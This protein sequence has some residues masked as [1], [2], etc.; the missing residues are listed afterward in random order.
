[1]DPRRRQQQQARP[2]AAARPA[3]RYVDA[4]SERTTRIV[5]NERQ[6][7]K[8]L[9]SYLTLDVPQRFSHNCKAPS[10][11][12]TLHIPTEDT[13]ADI[14]KLLSALVTVLHYSQLLNRLL[15]KKANFWK[16][17][18][19]SEV[20]TNMQFNSTA[21]RDWMLEDEQFPSKVVLK[22]ANHA[23]AL[24]EALFKQISAFFTAKPDRRFRELLQLF[25][26]ETEHV[27]RCKHISVGLMLKGIKLEARSVKML[28]HVVLDQVRRSARGDR[29][30]CL[31]MLDLSNNNM[32][33]EALHVVADILK[34]ND[35]YKLKHVNLT[36][37]TGREENLARD[38]SSGLTAIIQASL[39]D[40]VET[41]GGTR[42]QNT[43]RSMSTLLL[44]ENYLRVEHYT[45]LCSA[46]RYDE[47]LQELE[48]AGTMSSGMDENERAQCWQWIAFGLFYRRLSK[49]PCDRINSRKIDLSM[50]SFTTA[51][52]DAFERA[53]HTP[54]ELLECHGES[55]SISGKS[56]SESSLP[57]A[58]L[59]QCKIKEGAV[60]HSDPDL[61]SEPLST[62][63]ETTQL[64]CL[65]VDD[66]WSCV[67]LP[68]IGLGWVETTGAVLVEQVNE[69]ES[70][71]PLREFLPKAA[72]VMNS[73]S[74][75]NSV[76]LC[77]F[78]RTT[79]QQLVSLELQHN[80]CM[81][82][83]VPT[84]LSYCINLQCLSLEGWITS[85]RDSSAYEPDVLEL[86]QALGGDFGRQLLSLDLTGNR[87]DDAMIAIL[88]ASLSASHQVPALQHL[89]LCRSWMGERGLQSLSGALKVNRTL[90][91]L[92]LDIPAGSADSLPRSPL[93]MQLE[94]VRLDEAFDSE[95]LW[96]DPLSLEAKLAFLSVLTTFSG[97]SS[98][99]TS[100]DTWVVSS[101]FDFAR[102]GVRRR[103][104]WRQLLRA[105][106]DA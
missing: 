22:V 3:H 13:V 80:S 34:R 57:N 67:V 99:R 85:F 79:G 56:H 41:Y 47:T 62:V 12:L 73:I 102:R 50:S 5:M 46:L 82:N 75:P 37:I 66:H 74:W 101:V 26:I 6:S 8:S 30:F 36:N 39:G 94:A 25:P 35:V 105:E 51:D 55:S 77:S 83:V 27:R 87:I 9:R 2:R 48:L 78:I 63:K 54:A 65:W 97:D 33:A 89:R 84:I 88:A 90:S 18:L 23:G 91:C 7:V 60:I 44:N 103:I 24:N 45:A 11:S 86:F 28:Q 42:Q 29:W 49:S 53:L 96:C 61:T 69:Q 43:E 40:F 16:A 100:I 10:C 19:F 32:D 104:I 72:V 76:P 64:E 71:V 31:D 52:T 38:V 4:L 58:A 59:A 15:A 92:E 20:T 106:V 81:E 98:T 17:I 95:L 68:G 21:V 93:P 1:M 70:F 14:E